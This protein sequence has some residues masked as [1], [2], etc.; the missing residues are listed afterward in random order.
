MIKVSDVLGGGLKEGGSNGT[1]GAT[2][3]K[4][5]VNDSTNLPSTSYE[6][7][8]MRE[9]SSVPMF[10]SNHMRATTATMV[11]RS[12]VLRAKV[13]RKSRFV[14]K[15]PQTYDPQSSEEKA[16]KVEND[17]Y[18]LEDCAEMFQPLENRQGCSLGDVVAWCRRSEYFTRKLLASDA[19]RIA[20]QNVD[21][22]FVNNP[23]FSETIREY[24]LDA[25]VSNAIS[26]NVQVPELYKISLGIFQSILCT[27]RFREKLKSE[28]G[29]FFPRLFLDPLGFVSGGAP[30]SPHS[31]RSV[32]LSILSDT[33]AQDAQTLVDV[34]VNFD[35]DISQQNAFER[36]INLLVRVA[37]GVELSNLSGADAARE[38]VLKMESSG[39]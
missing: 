1:T 11:G 14:W 3:Q 30:S 36:L 22:V 16:A 5:D 7:H 13:H 24:V 35:C 9:N 20:C 28:I 21:D 4:N 39:V 34:F 32:V 26:E 2:P 19:L 27:Q 8:V 33:A 23:I 17:R 12:R 18:V 38:T 29:F 31:K 15:T 25:A 10:S 6:T 37:Q